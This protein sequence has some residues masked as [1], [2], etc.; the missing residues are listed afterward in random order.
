MGVIKQEKSISFCLSKNTSFLA[1]Q[2]SC[3]LEYSKERVPG[4]G[5]ATGCGLVELDQDR[6]AR[7][8]EFYNSNWEDYYGTDNVFIVE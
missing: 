3:I 7:M 1:R 5:R 8:F 6:L 2:I 4:A